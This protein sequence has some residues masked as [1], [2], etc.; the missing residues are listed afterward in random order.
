MGIAYFGMAAGSLAAGS[1]MDLVGRRK[2]LSLSNIL[3]AGGAFMQAFAIGFFGLFFG[4]VL[5]G[6][7]IGMGLA[8][9][10]AYIAEVSPAHKRGLFSSAEELFI[11]IGVLCGY[12]ANYVLLG[13]PHDWRWM[14]GLGGVIPLLFVPMLLTSLFPESPRYLFQKGR[15][16]EASQVLSV[17][18]SPDE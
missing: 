1:L 6:F 12:L 4:R 14:L 15:H 16:E 7:G 5:V 17:L 9:V 18:V 8:T 13:I 2:V 3:L 11:T 10:S